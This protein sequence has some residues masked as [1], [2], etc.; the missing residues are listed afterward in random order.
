MN[1]KQTEKIYSPYRKIEDFMDETILKHIQISEGYISLEYR[2]TLVFNNIDFTSVDEINFFK[3]NIKIIKKAKI[4]DNL[5]NFEKS[6]NITINAIHKKA[7]PI[8]EE[9]QEIGKINSITKLT[10]IDCILN[11]L[12]I[13][14]LSSVVNLTL[15]KSN[16]K[17]R[18]I[19]EKKDI[20]YL[21]FRDS[22]FHSKVEIKKCNI[23]N[24]CNFENTRF[25]DFCDFEESIFN[26][27]EFKNTVF[28]KLVTFQKTKFTKNMDFHYVTFKTHSIFK[29][30]IFE[31]SVNFE[32]T[33]FEV[34]GSFYGIS[35]KEDKI[36]IIDVANR[37][38][39]RIIKNSFE[40]QNNIIEANKFYALEMKEREKELSKKINKE[41]IVDWII[42]KLHGLS[43]NH[44]QDSILPVFWIL[45]IAFIYS[46]FLSTFY[47]NNVLAYFS[48]AISLVSIVR[49][50]FIKNDIFLKVIL[51]I[52]LFI[53]SFFS[54]VTFATVADL[55]NPFSI[56]TS[57]DPITFGL[58]IFKIIIAYLIYQFIVSIRQNTR[59]K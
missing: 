38:T 24:D 39:A 19:I 4:G 25:K 7:I 51:G 8:E 6:I 59:R 44:S 14:S 46:M 36:E 11:K 1:E 26:E 45:N 41:N 34:D 2:D 22:I 33:L 48:V 16:I 28:E 5:S 42:F 20:E 27:V 58:L 21:D 3:E 54:F 56:M 37:E 17:D 15:Q 52:S 23:T 9:S 30:T 12:Q 10:F 31:K 35:S 47:H 18:L 13:D 32:N 55:I 40:Q 53:S 49:Y 57:K 50:I 43:S 29:H